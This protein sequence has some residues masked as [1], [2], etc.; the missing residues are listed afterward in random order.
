MFV[1]GLIVPFVLHSVDIPERI[2]KGVDQ[3]KRGD[4]GCLEEWK[5]GKLWLGYNV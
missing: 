1:P 2:S 3:G 5:E 4:G